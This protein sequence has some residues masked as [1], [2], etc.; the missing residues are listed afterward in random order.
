MLEIY[1]AAVNHLHARS[2]AFALLFAISVASALAC[3]RDPLERA[4]KLQDGEQ[5]FTQSLE[6]LREVLAERPDDP[7]ANYRYGLALLASGQ[8][9]LAK[10]SLRKALDSV[11][12]VERA[13][14][15]LA[16][17]AIQLGG[18]DEAVE[19]ATRVLEKF[20]ENVDALMLRA[21]ARIR[22]RRQYEEALA[23][24]ERALELDPENQGA[25][26][27]KVAALLAL[28][29]VDEATA[30]L[31]A[32]ERRYSDES[33]GLHGSPTL[34]TARA[35]FAKERGDLETAEKRFAE[36]IE[37]F[38]SDATV[39]RESVAF[40]DAIG[41]AD[42][43]EEILKAAL[44]KAPNAFGY[45]AALVARYR[46]AGREA[47]AEA[48]LRAATELDDPASAAVGWSAVALYSIETGKFDEAAQA[49]ER[50]R[51][52]D[53]TG[54]TE[55]LF[56]YADALV[57]AGRH[58]EALKIADQMTVPA[59][60]SLVKGRVALERMDPKLALE[61]LG[62]GN[63]LWPNNA[64]ARYY[65]AIA[66]EQLGDFERAV[67]EYRYAMRVDVRA[68]DAYLRLARLQAA[69][70]QNDLALAS[71]EF[72]PG[73]RPEEDA[74]ALF[75]LELAA[76][77]NRVPPPSILQR[78]QRERRPAAAAALARGFAARLGPKRA[79]DFLRAQKDIDLTDPQNAETLAAFV[80]LTAANG[81]PRDGLARVEAAL[82][83][84]AESAALHALRGDAL[85]A[86]GSDASAARAADQRALEIEPEQHRALAGLAALDA[87][88][89]ARESALAW[90]QRAA[91]ADANDRAS[92]RTAA[93]LLA[94]LGRGEEG[95]ATL[96]QLLRDHP[97]DAEAAIALAELRRAR[98]AERDVTEELAK[99]AV[100]FGGGPAAQELL[101][102]IEAERNA[103]A[104][105]PADASS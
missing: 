90:Y 4:R 21:D 18:Y 95:E 40:F 28:E 33:L 23:D 67:E 30:A 68:T 61:H 10:W 53:P 31:D 82:A 87:K 2:T 76:R 91:R 62:E 96:A 78:L 93:N 55:I 36:C 20:P 65:A 15:P 92:A 29:R 66:A 60:R 12:W 38:P 26:V 46:N 79:V 42:R 84:H 88:A 45:R 1:C 13:G 5:K 105:S 39:L 9:S 83:K 11:E 22:T 102:K 69:A 43:S 77:I 41:R 89:G 58:D 17:T 24:A 100:K 51:A 32:L 101:D 37:H 97:Y 25:M 56:G 44:D 81:A 75:E 34:C 35:T 64:V 50:A 70:G 99:R 57:V 7:E 80:E 52:S 6:P 74:A 27:P 48:L 103:T 63:R 73:G 59:H 94:E 71:L 19:V 86:T 85:A 98:G 47:D 14:I 8:P 16:T 54:S 72:S 49:F 3:S 104:A